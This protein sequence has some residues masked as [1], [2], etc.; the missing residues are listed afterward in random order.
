MGRGERTDTYRLDGFRVNG[1]ASVTPI[2]DDLM[3]YYAAKNAVIVAAQLRLGNMATRLFLH[4]ALECWDDVDN[5]RGMAPRRYFG[6]REMSAI[7][8][9]FLA[10]DNGAEQ[11]FVA[12]KRA[13]RE[14][15]AKGAI[16]RIRRAG[17]G[18][19]A[20]YELQLESARPPKRETPAAGAVVLP[21]VPAEQVAGFRTPQRARF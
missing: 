1:L 9:G 11:A 7:A 10:P 4:M 13:I 14:L 6:R 5:P 3:G 2:R 21:F 12:V 19:P 17:N 15:V 8:L 20:E 16:V 18:R